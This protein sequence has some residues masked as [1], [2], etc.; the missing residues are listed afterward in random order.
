MYNVY[1]VGHIVVAAT[2]IHTMATS[3][4]ARL[5]TSGNRPLEQMSQIRT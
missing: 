3:S 1:T 5:F 2:E 4:M